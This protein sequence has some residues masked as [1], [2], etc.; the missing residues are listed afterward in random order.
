[1]LLTLLLIV[2]GLLGFVALIVPFIFN[3]Q[4]LY[5]GM[6]SIQHFPL[7]VSYHRQLNQGVYP[8]FD[9][10]FSLGFDSLADSQQSLIHP[11]KILITVFMDDAYSIDTWF[12]ILHLGLLLM[13]LGLYVYRLFALENGQKLP[14]IC[15]AAFASLSFVL[16]LAVYTNLIHI[17]Y[18]PVLSYGLLLLYFIDKN[19]ENASTLSLVGIAMSSMLL[20]LCGNFT[21]QWVIFGWI[22]IYTLV[23]LYILKQSPTRML[24]LLIAFAG[25]LMLAA[26][27]LLPTLDLMLSSSRA[28]SGEASRFALSPGP[29]QWFSYL[30]PGATFFAYEHADTVY[31]FMVGNNVVEGVHYVGVVTLVLFFCSVREYR[32]NF[33]IAI[34]A[35]TLLL[36]C[37]RALGVFSPINIFLNFVP[38]F[39]QFRASVRYLFVVDI[40]IC[41][42]AAIYLHSHFNR[43]RILAAINLTLLLAISITVIILIISTIQF[44]YNWKLYPTVGLFESFY[45]FLPIFFL[46]AA[47]FVLM[48]KEL[49]TRTIVA[50][51]FSLTIVDLSSHRFGAPTHYQVPTVSELKKVTSEFDRICHSKSDTNIM[52]IRPERW[53]NTWFRFDLPIFPN[54]ENTHNLYPTKSTQPTLE[55]NGYDCTLTHSMKTSTLTPISTVEL[56]NWLNSLSW[57]ER[58]PLFSIL[59]FNKVVSYDP[60]KAAQPLTKDRKMD[61]TISVPLEPTP[62]QIRSL[63]EFVASQPS[64]NRS[65]FH[66]AIRPIYEFIEKL[67][68]TDLLPSTIRKPHTLPGIG[69][70]IALQAPFSFIILRN[71]EEIKPIGTKGSFVVLPGTSL[72]SVEV[73]FVPVAFLLGLMTTIITV[74]V[75]VLILLLR[76]CISTGSSFEEGRYHR[77]ITYY[78]DVII[79]GLNAIGG[80][81]KIFLSSVLAILLTVI[82]LVVLMLLL[83]KVHII[84]QLLAMAALI[85]LAY[86]LT[87]FITDNKILGRGL[88]IV[89]GAM[90]LSGIILMGIFNYLHGASN[91]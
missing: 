16:S 84:L 73:K 79:S 24:S 52:L 49:G 85:F 86:K 47:K 31:G 67:K 83:G 78:I 50:I 55:L 59:G 34:L 41:I 82:I 76:S 37:L 33:K 15:A 38:I 69:Q 61:L 19:I 45:I 27:Q 71:Q 22:F 63:S 14:A 18:V 30:I 56:E 32:S 57:S 23:R 42:I 65:I 40:L 39:G 3:N 54:R 72:D 88:A 4:V 74:I 11:V 44:Y 89:L 26:P 81:G 36:I 6:I 5:G 51:L 91:L 80:N 60:I 58:L 29:F 75:G 64:Q 77:S 13:V 68:L 21:M 35:V 9:F 8:F 25:G 62:D 20:S 53:D 70:V 12:I 90:H 46:L 66:F 17:Y 2:I 43:E 28:A 7:L 10:N 87:C 48:R 1:M